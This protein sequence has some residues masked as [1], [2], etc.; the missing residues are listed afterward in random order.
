MIEKSSAASFAAEWIASWNGH[1]LDRILSHYADDLE[2][3]SPLIVRRLGEP[4]GRLRGKQAVGAYWAKGL[5][6]R[7]DLTFEL[8]AVFRGV[9]SLV[10][11]YR[12][13]DGLNAC[14]HF[15]FNAAGKV[16]RSSAHHE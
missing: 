5:A 13:V 4:S 15:E 2:F 7:P 1:D 10:I 9:G 11:H 16:V 14:E 6:R 8:R 3:T 12:D